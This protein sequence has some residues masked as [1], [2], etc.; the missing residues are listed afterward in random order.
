MRTCVMTMKHTDT[1]WTIYRNLK[2][3]FNKAVSFAHFIYIYLK[4]MYLKLIQML[5]KVIQV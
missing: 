5:W 3:Y 2:V 1:P 4:Y